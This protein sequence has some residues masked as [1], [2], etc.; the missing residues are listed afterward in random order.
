MSKN[1]CVEITVPILISFEVEDSVAAD[2]IALLAA[3]K[4]AAQQDPK[5]K[6]ETVLSRTEYDAAYDA[7]MEAVDKL[8]SHFAATY[9]FGYARNV[10]NF[11]DTLQRIPSFA[12]GT[13]D[14]PRGL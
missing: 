10:V 5:D 2:P 11:M 7:A 8:R 6:P 3:T 13:D 14:R 12:R 4:E 9:E 1:V